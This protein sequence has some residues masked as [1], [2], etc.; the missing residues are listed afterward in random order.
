M[1]K[2]IKIT[3]LFLLLALVSTSIVVYTISFLQKQVEKKFVAYNTNALNIKTE[4]C[5]KCHADIKGIEAS[6]SPEKIGCYSCHLGNP[7]SFSKNEAHE[8]M[9]LIPG[10]IADLEKTCSSPNCHPQMLPRMKN[11]LMNT[12]NGVVTVDK[13]VFDEASSPTFKYSVQEIKFSPA[14]KHLR[15]LCASCHLSNI[16]NELGPIQ[17]LSRG[18][19]CL[20]CH[21]NYSDEALKEINQQK[22]SLTKFHP[23]ISLKIDNTHCFGCHSR[24]GRISLS[25]DGWHETLL[26][27][28]EVK[29]K[30]G[31]RILDDGR[32]VQQI[33]KDV[34]SESG[35]L[36][37]DCHIST[38]IMGDGNYYLHKEEQLR[39]K[40]EDCHLSTKPETKK[41]NQFDFESRKI[42]ELIGTADEKKNFI[43]TKSGI[44]YTNLYFENSKAFLI[45]KSTKQKIEIK[46]PS[47]ACSEGKAHKNLSCN[48][49]HNSWTPQC[50]GCH[51]EYDENS[52]MYDLLDNKEANGEWLEH[53]KDLIAESTTL[54]VKEIIEDG[55][56][57]KEIIEVMPGMI[58]TID[59]SKKEKQIF[60]RLFAPAFSHTIRKE[61]KTCEDCHL[62]SVV[63][64]YGRG[65]LKFSVE[66][67]KGKFVFIPKYSNN[68]NDNL[69]EDAWTGFLKERKTNSATRENIRTFSVEEQKRI[70][71]L[72]SCLTCHKSNSSIIKATLF[73]FDKT[74][75]LRSKAC[76][77]PE[78]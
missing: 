28:E 27:P 7:K 1:N 42:V 44:P 47:F 39:I 43:T 64:G 56:K 35:L 10:N 65:E 33:K 20:A 53:P 32:V 50:I 45:K 54:G 46:K 34:H 49:C 26:K 11:N 37:V 71:T 16:K 22:K 75:K 14:E 76:I 3:F 48:T 24:S 15:N 25:Y 5:L 62:N 67:K 70:L 60:K 6:H 23:N 61:S 13:W 72:G 9:I 8:N 38:E 59:K 29:S 36:C 55:E 18:G 77:I 31:F 73:D 66:D 74:I 63:L 41:I 57:K 68:K 69:P 30:I 58:L 12:M 51:T 78:W 21:L 19:G 52:T 2:K 17:E 40:C 4:S